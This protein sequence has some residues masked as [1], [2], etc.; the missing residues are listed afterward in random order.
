M[1]LSVAHV[2][3]ACFCADIWSKSQISRRL[4]DVAIAAAV[5]VAAW[6][7]IA[8]YFWIDGRWSFFYDTLFRQNITYSG[9]VG[10]NVLSAF[11]PRNLFPGFVLWVFAILPLVFA[12]GVLDRSWMKSENRPKLLLWIA[13]AAGSALAVALPGKFF[14]HY[15]QLWMPVWCTAAG[16]AA[17]VLIEERRS[18]IKLIN[19]TLLSG[20][21]ACLALC[22]IKHYLLPADEWARR[23]YPSDYFVQQ[24]QMGARL[25]ALLSP[26]QSFYNVGED[27]PLY[28]YS[29]RSPASGLLYLSPLE[30][31]ADAAKYEQRLL[32][33]LNRSKPDMIVVSPRGDQMLS[34]RP[35]LAGWIERNYV[36]SNSNLGC[37]IYRIM[38]KPDSSL[39]RRLD[40]EGNAMATVRESE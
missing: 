33:D 19:R 5:V 23:K 22:Q 40:A 1:T 17:S 21:I 39:A 27:N 10:G 2:L 4:T 9:N 16:W 29:D 34:Q 11:L 31:G 38:V 36:Q 24:R 7:V 3:G 15:Y 30:T 13:W 8:G 28:F 26:G 12:A 32:N 6:T 25:A 14:G 37:P 18:T 35:G 20:A